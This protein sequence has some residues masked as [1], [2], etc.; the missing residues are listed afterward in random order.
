MKDEIQDPE[1]HLFYLS[2]LE[3]ILNQPV[4]LSVSSF[5]ALFR[6]RTLGLWRLVRQ[7]FI[8]T[9]LV[10]LPCLTGFLFLTHSPGASF[11]CQIVQG[12]TYADLLFTLG[13][14]HWSRLSHLGECCSF[15]DWPLKF[16]SVATWGFV[17][18]PEWK[19]LGAQ[20]PH[21]GMRIKILLIPGI[22][23][24]MLSS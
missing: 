16:G 14:K 13:K 15:P 20:W 19:E 5:V 23:K 2:C 24:L 7:S 6:N 3:C 9:I 1:R 8:I 22:S 21:A 11:S 4:F 12:N 10:L 18:Y 17:F